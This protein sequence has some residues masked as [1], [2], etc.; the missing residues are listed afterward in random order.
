MY[1]MELII[2]PGALELQ[3]RIKI[4]PGSE[5]LGEKSSKVSIVFEKLSLKKKASR[6]KRREG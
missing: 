3:V 5:Y 4:H 6:R 1:L 2:Y